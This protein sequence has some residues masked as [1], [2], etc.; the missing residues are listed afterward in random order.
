MNRKKAVVCSVT[1]ILV[2]VISQLVAGLLSNVF[3]SVG[4]PKVICNALAG[5]IYFTVTLIIVAVFY[6]KIMHLDVKELGIKKFSIKNKWILIGLILPIA[7]EIFYI[8]MISG[9]YLPSGMSNKKIAETLSLGIIYTGLGT[10]FV[11]EIVFR[12]IIFRSLEKAWNT[13]IAVIVPSVLFGIVHILG[14]SFSVGSAL[15]VIL[16]GTAV[17]IMFSMITIESGSI[18][19]NGLV[20]AF[21]N[22]IIIGD[23]LSIGEKADKLS[24]ANYVLDTNK[25]ALTGGEFGIESSVVALVGY[26]IVTVI[27]VYMIKRERHLNTLPA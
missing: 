13:K 21:W 3:G 6:G 14:K 5:I 24:V 15:L 27:A 2:L 18:W 22:M 10:G 16:A 20:H 11:E 26:I 25:F 12:G 9:K 23:G 1:A 17:G 4:V 8:L 7:V 19:C